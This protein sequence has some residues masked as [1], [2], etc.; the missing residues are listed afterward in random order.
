MLCILCIQAHECCARYLLP[1]IARLYRQ[2]WLAI[3][4]CDEEFDECLI[5]YQT[6]CAH[7][8]KLILAAQVRSNSLELLCAHPVM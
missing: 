8:A 2:I 3:A 4:N 5:D 7:M 6:E 1:T